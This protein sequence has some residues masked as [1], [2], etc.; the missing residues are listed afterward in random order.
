MRIS[1]SVVD[2]A[3]CA[4][5]VFINTVCCTYR[6][7]VNLATHII[8]RAIWAC[9]HTTLLELLFVQLSCNYY[10]GRTDNRSLIPV[11]P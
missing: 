7:R 5:L 2:T 1:G 6:I 11:A 9:S 3:Y 4:M 8:V 10:C